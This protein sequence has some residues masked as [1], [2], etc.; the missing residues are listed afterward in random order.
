MKKLSIISLLTLILGTLST[1]LVALTPTSRTASPPYLNYQFYYNDSTASTTA[2]CSI[3]S[4]SGAAY[5]VCNFYNTI[6]SS[7]KNQVICTVSYALFPTTIAAAAIDAP[8]PAD[9]GLQQTQSMINNTA[10]LVHNNNG[11]FILSF[12]ES[13]ASFGSMP[14]SLGGANELS[15]AECYNIGVSPQQLANYLA[16][17][18]KTY[19]LDGIDF[20]IQKINPAISGYVNWIIDVI[21]LASKIIPFITLTVPG[22]SW[23]YTLTFTPLLNNTWKLVNYINFIEHWYFTANAYPTAPTNA[24]TTNT[25]T[26]G[27]L[28]QIIYDLNQYNGSATKFNIPFSKMGIVIY[29]ATSTF[30]PNSNRSYCPKF[31]AELANQAHSVFG[32]RAYLYNPKGIYE[33]YIFSYSYPLS[34]GTNNYPFSPTKTYKTTNS[35]NHFYYTTSSSYGFNGNTVNNELSTLT[36]YAS[37]VGLAGLTLYTIDQEIAQ[38]KDFPVSSAIVK[39][40]QT[41]FSPTS[42]TNSAAKRRRVPQKINNFSPLLFYS[43]LNLH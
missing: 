22:Q 14:S 28:N 3:G 19:N 5:P 42:P 20:N 38:F 32:N 31:Q 13:I 43:R 1:S 34:N 7:Q 10:Q 17:V 6:T 9:L 16:N 18:V 12:G 35:T 37:I 11:L 15:L 40:F 21:T 39:A 24:S 29:V 26:P 8:T 25:P 41:P 2:P 36:K 33:Q 30:S 4:V 27:M 23:A